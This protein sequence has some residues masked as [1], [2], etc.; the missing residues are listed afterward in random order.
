MRKAFVAVLLTALLAINIVV[1]KA[2]ELGPNLEAK[3]VKKIP[4]LYPPL[5]KRKRV[6][7]KVTIRLEIGSEGTV[8][9]AEFVEGN[10][11]FKPSSLDAAKQWT[12]AK[13]MAGTTGHIV[14]KFQLEEK[15]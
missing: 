1:V 14:F 8:S 6:E 12:F 15:E 5:A 13:S 10:S 11:L 9:N 3:A 2:F 7:G 4:P